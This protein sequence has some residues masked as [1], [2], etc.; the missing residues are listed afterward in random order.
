M[1][2]NKLIYFLLT[3]LTCLL[4]NT[5]KAQPSWSVDAH[6][7][8]YS[9]TL[10]GK[11]F[12]DG[13]YSAD[14]ND[15]VGA[16]INGECR[17]ISNVKYIASVNDYFVFLM[18]YSNSPIDNVTFRIF[19]K[20][21]NQDY[22]AKESAQFSVNGNLGTSVNPFVFTAANLNN[23]SDILSFSIPNQVGST[24]IV[25][26]TIS[27]QEAWRINN[28]QGIVASFTLSPGA[29]AYINGVEQVSGVTVNDFNSAVQYTVRSED[30]LVSSL[31]SINISPANDV[32]TDILLSHSAVSENAGP[33][34]IGTLA[35]VTANPAETHV[36]SLFDGT[37]TSNQHF[38]IV[39]N[40]LSSSVNFNYE[41]VSSYLIRVKADDL[42]G[43]VVEK[44]FTIS[45][46]DINEAPTKIQ[47]VSIVTPALA[48]V[49]T[50]VAS[51]QA[52]DPDAGDSH[53]FNLQIGDGLNDKDNWR[54]VVEG[55]KLKC[56]INVYFGKDDSYNILLK[57]TD[58]KGAS[59]VVPLSVATQDEGGLSNKSALMSFTIN[60]QIGQTIFSGTNIY[61]QQHWSGNLSA[62][63][64]NFTIPFGAKA[65]I[66][67]VE[68][69]GGASV[70]DYT[71]PVQLIV[72]AADK[73]S[74]TY[75]IHVTATNDIPTDILLSSGNI[76]ENAASTLVGTLLAVTENPKETHV[77]TLVNELGTDYDLFKINGSELQSVGSFD[78]E[79]KS[80]Y[81]IKV[82][83]DDQKGGIVD[84][85]F[86]I[87][88]T[89]KNEAPTGISLSNS[90]FETGA[91]ANTMIG[92]LTAEDQDV[93]ESHVF[94]LVKGNG[95]NDDGNG[96]V[97]VSGNKLLLAQAT[98][99]I[100][101]L[102]WNILIKVV[103]GANASFEK[104]IIIKSRGINH[105]PVFNSK[106]ATYVIQNQTYVYPIE[107]SDID[108]DVVSLKF[109]NLPKWLNYNSELNLL[110][111]SPGNAEVGTYSFT[112]TASDNIAIVSQKVAILV[113]DINDAPEINY[114]IDNQTFITNKQNTFIIPNDCFKDPDAGDKLTY[115]VTMT[116]N[117]IMPAWLSFDSATRTLRGSPTKDAFGT[118]QLKV[119]A[120]DQKLAKE[121]M[122]FSLNVSFPTAVINIED[123]ESF[124]VFPNP[125][126][127]VLNLKLPDK[128]GKALVQVLDVHG[129][130][131][132]QTYLNEGEP[133]TLFLGNLNPGVYFVTSS[134]GKSRY[135]SKIIKE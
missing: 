25:G 101:K 98:N 29:R 91:A 108:G 125:V 131:I 132:Q 14:V 68:Q 127:D 118:Y 44:N 2:I 55:N 30:Q 45:V 1:K 8:M 22:A 77:Y 107:I 40:Q 54:F 20:S 35:A 31:Y 110:T 106:P 95:T 41:L 24:A 82:R 67:L 65:Y 61:L 100:T 6:Q 122:I 123:S 52:T 75:L 5:A 43:G 4:V 96:L 103:D 46:S 114:F 49:N 16:F 109:E 112:I 9:M 18:V 130:M 15:M 80:S 56:R 10:T 92:Y 102:Q 76:P 79:S 69:S 78:F 88:V 87:T 32:P 135:V 71:N 121:W 134:D 119:T 93:G 17:G 7:Y 3:S 72:E 34:L 129:K 51:L 116:N 94:S 27:L 120:T 74:T 59:I 90:E 126:R 37:G 33:A 113:L 89:D 104:S 50:E 124:I 53:T 26:K 128:I 12:S 63:L 47:L 133:Q 57:A 81:K 73:S 99:N 105:I 66:N 97:K 111:G 84:K 48:L 19:D 13:S 11:I 60:Q 85:I 36:Y 64:A 70:N 86:S 39:G 115:S 21:K 23:Q 117:S 83:A 58:K 38:S 62:V 28:L 42:K